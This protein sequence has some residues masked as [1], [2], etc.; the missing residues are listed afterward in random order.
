MHGDDAKCRRQWQSHALTARRQADTTAAS[1]LARTPTLA[2]CMQSPKG[3]ATCSP[4]HVD[5]RLAESNGMR[6]LLDEHSCCCVG[7]VLCRD[8]Q[9]RLLACYGS[10]VVETARL[11]EW[12]GTENGRG[13]STQLNE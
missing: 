8:C 5:A 4:H 1:I 7:L 10:G 2:G 12:R 3:R 9:L 13:K 11:L 6:T